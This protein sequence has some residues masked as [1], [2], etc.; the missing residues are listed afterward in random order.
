MTPFIEGKEP[1]PLLFTSFVA[2]VLDQHSDEDAERGVKQEGDK[3]RHVNYFGA[4]G[5]VANSFQ[6]LRLIRRPAYNRR[7]RIVH[8]RT[9]ELFSRS[10]YSSS[11]HPREVN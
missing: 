2:M 9:P 7:Y 6:I 4:C 3:F 5:F 1:L 11:E 8:L 10:F